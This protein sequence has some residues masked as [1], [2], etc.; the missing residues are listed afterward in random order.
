MRT[1]VERDM[2]SVD[3]RL[4]KRCKMRDDC[5]RLICRVK[6]MRALVAMHGIILEDCEFFEPIKER[7]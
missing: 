7:K 1:E 5:L 4:C 6:V 2:R 3:P